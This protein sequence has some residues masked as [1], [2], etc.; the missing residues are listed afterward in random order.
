MNNAN[1][2]LH[3]F[4][5]QDVKFSSIDLSK[6][7]NL[8]YLRIINDE[9]LASIDLSKN[10]YIGTLILDNASISAID[11]SKQTALGELRLNGTG[12]TSL[13]LSKNTKLNTLSIARTKIDSLDL[14]HNPDMDFLNVNNTKISSLD[15]SINTKLRSFY[16]NYSQ[17]S[18][19]NL[20]SDK[21]TDLQIRNT[22]ITSLDTSGYP[23]LRT[24]YVGN[25]N[26]KKLDLSKNT[27]LQYLVADNAKL[28][29][30]DISKNTQLFHIEV[31]DIYIIPSVS[32]D[33]ATKR[34]FDLSSLKYLTRKTT[35]SYD[36]DDSFTLNWDTM[37][38]AINDYDAFAGYVHVAPYNPS[39]KCKL[40]LFNNK[41]PKETS[42]E[43]DGNTPETV[44]PG[45]SVKNPNTGD[46]IQIIALIALPFAACLIF[47]ASKLAK[48]R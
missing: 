38:V 2:N 11:L 41:I 22:K 24:L 23:S 32:T 5:L 42:E 12:I 44:K 7:P 16:A 30:L 18:S 45:K 39:K 21:I 34:N 25:T 36:A 1:T 4:D 26:I 17:L 31:D 35:D 13:D 27:N 33:D 29:R 28:E 3:A 40:V 6:V 47:G 46:N 20:P 8:V 9:N 15:L 43:T 19:L 14:S 37:T 10:P 48:R